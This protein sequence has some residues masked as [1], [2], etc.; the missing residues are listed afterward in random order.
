[1]TEG[2]QLSVYLI[3]HGS[4]DEHEYKFNIAGPDLTDSDILEAL[5]QVPSGNQVLVNTSSAS[6]AGGELWQA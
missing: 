3:G 2:D 6:G 1:M 4:Y 5:N